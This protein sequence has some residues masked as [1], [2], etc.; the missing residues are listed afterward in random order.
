MTA[1]VCV[2]LMSLVYNC[3]YLPRATL[4]SINNGMPIMSPRN[5]YTTAR[6]ASSIESYMPSGGIVL[7]VVSSS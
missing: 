4:F 2:V 6:T 3:N 1:Y 5:P 7:N